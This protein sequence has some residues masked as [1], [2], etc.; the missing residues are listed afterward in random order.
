MPK[1][2]R[3]NSKDLVKILLKN[4]F[5][6][7]IRKGSHI[8]LVNSTDE[9]IRLTIPMHDKDLPIGTLHAIVKD[10]KLDINIFIR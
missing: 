8:Q 9:T 1:L 4:N 5:Y 7:S 10:S 3:I 6:I 2:I